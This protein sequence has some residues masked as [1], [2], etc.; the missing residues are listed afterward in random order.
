MIRQAHHERLNLMALGA[1]SLPIEYGQPIA[2]LP[3][4]LNAIMRDIGAIIFW[5]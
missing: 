4:L 3:H 2:N 5:R 1:T